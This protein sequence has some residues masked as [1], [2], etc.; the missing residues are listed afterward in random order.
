MRGCRGDL[1]PAHLFPASRVWTGAIPDGLIWRTGFMSIRTFQAGDDVVQVGIYNEAAAGLPRFKPATLDEVRRRYRDPLFDPQTHFFASANGVVVGYATFH[2]NGRVSYPWCRKGH[3]DEAEALFQAVLAEMQRRSLPSAFAA[4][5]GNWPDQRG[6]FLAHGFRQ[7]R[8]MVNFSIDLSDLPTPSLGSSGAIQ[9]LGVEDVPT[10]FEL[11]EGVL[12]AKSAD[13]LKEQLF[14][15]PLADVSTAFVLR[16]RS[17]A[18]LRAVGLL[19]FDASFADPNQVDAGM[20]CFR[21]GAFGTEGLQT[22]RIQG[23]FSFLARPGSHLNPLGLELLSHA[24]TQLYRTDLGTMAAQ[25]PSDAPHLL[26]FYQQIFRK[27]GSFP[28][29]VRELS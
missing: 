12:R 3:E 4:Y 11:G 14:G 28:V 6:F 15:P 7:I 22:K 13:A 20:P 23:L 2:A 27:Q 5:R 1:L 17:G 29:F 26:R 21:L 8:E 25:V 16:D 19:V 9:P 10:V 24:A 18:T